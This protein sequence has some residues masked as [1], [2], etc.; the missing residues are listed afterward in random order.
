MSFFK[1]KKEQ[2]PDPQANL[3]AAAAETRNQRQAALKNISSAFTGARQN[4]DQA[5]NRFNPQ[6]SQALFDR[7]LDRYQNFEQNAKLA[8]DNAYNA[9]YQ[10]ILNEVQANLGNQFAG[11]GAAGRGN[12][13][14]QFA[15]AVLSQ[16]LADNAGKQLMGIRN[17]ARNN[18]LQEN[19]AL[20][21]PAMDLQQQLVGIDTNK[22]NAFT[23]LGQTQANTR[24]G[25][26]SPINNLASQ[27]SQTATQQG[28]Q[29]AAQKSNNKG[30]I[31]SMIGG[32]MNLLGSMFGGRK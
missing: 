24:L 32:G 25:F 30:G 22:A 4:L 14:G 8:E 21:N 23:N 17:D 20:F 31:G 7:G 10:P 26:A 9:N 6:V 19:Q 28:Q 16:N 1:K 13:R 3:A 18:L 11:M 12:S 15:Q 29:A 27:Q 5:A 2:A